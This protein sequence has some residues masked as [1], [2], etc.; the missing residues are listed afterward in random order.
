MTCSD[1]R[2][3]YNNILSDD[4]IQRKQY[5]VISK[6][7]WAFLESN[8]AEKTKHGD[9]SHHVTHTHPIRR[10]YEKLNVG[11]RTFPDVHYHKVTIQPN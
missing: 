6:E 2:S 9:G 10:F 4:A 7:Q 5:Q 11:I 1:E 8:Y 3:P